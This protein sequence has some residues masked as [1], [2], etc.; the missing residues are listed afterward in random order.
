VSMRPRAQVR[1]TRVTASLTRQLLL[2][3]S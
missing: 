2:L 1:A 3:H